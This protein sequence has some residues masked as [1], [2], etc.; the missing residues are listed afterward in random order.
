[1]R[2]GLLA[3]TL[4]LVLAALACAAPCK[5]ASGE[6]ERREFERDSERCESQARRRLGYVDVGDYRSCMR[7]RGW[8]SA[9]EQD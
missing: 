5:D 2:S 4:G 9:P 7:V 3:L 6:S 8:C 1:M